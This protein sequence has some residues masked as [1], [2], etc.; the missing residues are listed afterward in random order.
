MPRILI[1]EDD[2]RL[3]R[4]TA[5]YL[6]KQGLEVDLERDG[7][8]GRHR[9][10]SEAPDLVVLDVMLPGEDGLSVCRAVRPDY[11]GPILML[12]A[13]GEEL[14]QVLGLELGADDY[15][16]KPVSPRLLLARIKALLRRP[17]A[18]PEAPGGA[19]VAGGVR[20]DPAL[21]EASIAGRPLDLTTAE[22]DLLWALAERAGTPV[23]RDDL[24]QQLRGIE[25]DGLDRSM[26]VRVSQ[27]RRKLE[28]AGADKG[29]IKTVR[30]TGYQLAAPSR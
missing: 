9:I 7:L 16:V 29:L 22:F 3:G 27:L 20:V 25:Y 17:V 18:A 1:I 15:V 14:D 2:E 13:R 21:R 24:F 5:E 30:G 6:R 28:A 23:T 4:L 26:D 12:T 19:V 11:A 10:L 8:R